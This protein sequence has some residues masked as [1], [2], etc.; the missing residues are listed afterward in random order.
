MPSTQPTT[1]CCWRIGHS[2]RRR[3][4][5]S[6]GGSSQPE[7]AQSDLST[8]PWCPRCIKEPAKSQGKPM[9]PSDKAALCSQAAPSPPTPERARPLSQS[10]LH[11]QEAEVVRYGLTVRGGQSTTMPEP[12]PKLARRGGLEMLAPALHP[13]Q[14]LEAQGRG[15]RFGVDVA[16]QP[17][18]ARR[19]MAHR[20]AVGQPSKRDGWWWWERSG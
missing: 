5:L 20:V 9:T 2:G 15:S 4:T 6:K 16:L 8:K 17:F 10:P 11:S 3:A 14:Q 18:F 13:T 1:A 12:S 19:S 7:G